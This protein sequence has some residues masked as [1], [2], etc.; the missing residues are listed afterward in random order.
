M[1]SELPDPQLK[2]ESRRRLMPEGSSFSPDLQDGHGLLHEDL[3][4][5]LDH[6]DTV[7]DEPVS[8]LL[9]PPGYGKSHEAKLAWTHLSS[10]PSV[11]GEYIH[12]TSFEKGGAKEAVTPGW[13]PRWSQDASA[14]A[15]WIVDAVDED[16]KGSQTFA[17]LK[18]IGTLKPAARSRLS[19]V[20]FCRENEFLRSIRNELTEI[21]PP[22][23]KRIV[24][25][26]API[27][28]DIARVIA[29][30]EG[31]LHRVCEIIRL[32]R[33]QQVARFPAVIRYLAKLP[34]QAR[35]TPSTV[36]RNVLTMMLIDDRRAEAEALNRPDEK[37]CFFAAKRLAACM[38][39]SGTA[40]IA[41]TSAAGLPNILSDLFQQHISEFARYRRAASFVLKTS[42]CKPTVDGYR[43]AQRHIQEWFAAFAFEE[44][45]L[46]RLRSLFVDQQGLMIPEHQGILALLA[47][48]SEHAEVR[49]WIPSLNDGVPLFSDAAPMTLTHAVETLDGLVTIANRA[50]FGLGTHRGRA[51]TGLAVHGL[52][53]IV[54]ARLKEK[55]NSP[56]AKDLL[57]DIAGVLRLVEA[58]P[59]AQDLIR[60]E[61]EDD[62]VRS[63]AV[64]LLE[65][66]ASPEQIQAVSMVAK[67]IPSARRAHAVFHA[68]LLSLLQERGIWTI[69]QVTRACRDVDGSADHLV[70]RLKD[71]MS[72]SDAREILRDFDWTAEIAAENA[73]NPPTKRRTHDPSGKLALGLEAI[74]LF[75]KAPALNRTDYD[76]LMPVVMALSDAYAR[77]LFREF[78]DALLHCFKQDKDARRALFR[79][80]L[81]SRLASA[82]VQGGFI[83]HVLEP[84]DASWL[85]DQCRAMKSVPDGV[86]DTLL[87]LSYRAKDTAEGADAHTFLTERIP[88]RVKEFYAQAEKNHA[89]YK[90]FLTEEATRKLT[91]KSDELQIAELITTILE[92]HKSQPY[93]RTLRIAWV[94][95]APDGH[96][97]TNVLGTWGDVPVE[98]KERVRAAVVEDLRVSKAPALSE[99]GAPTRHT[100]YLSYAFAWATSNTPEVLS[101]D[102]IRT[103]LPTLLHWSDQRNTAAL[104]ACH[105]ASETATEDV[106]LERIAQEARGLVVH[107]HL[108]ERLPATY[109]SPR[110]TATVIDLLDDGA[111]GPGPRSSLIRTIA[112]RAPTQALAIARCALASA[113]PE[114]KTAAID[115]LLMLEPSR[116]IEELLAF[117]D[118]ARVETLK[119]LE[120]LNRDRLD[121]ERIA[122]WSA[123]DL[124]ALHVLLDELPP[125]DEDDDFSWTTGITRRIQW[126]ILHVLWDRQGVDDLAAI[127]RIAAK[128]KSVLD[129]FE[130]QKSRQAAGTLLESI[131]PSDSDAKTYYPAAAFLDV[132]RVLDQA[133]FRLIRSPADL[134]LVVVEEIKTIAKTALDHLSMLYQPIKE[135][136]TKRR[137]LREEALQ[138]YLACRLQDRLP[139]RVLKDAKVH[140]EGLA[141]RNHR[142]DL[143]IDA[144]TIE[145]HLVSIILELKWS[146]NESLLESLRTQLGDDYLETQNLTHGVYVVG[147]LR[148]KGQIKSASAL[149]EILEEQATEYRS[150]PHG[151]VIAPLVLDL[152]WPYVPPTKKI[153]PKK[154][155]KAQ[156]PKR[157]VSAK[158]PA[159]PKTQPR[160]GKPPAAKRR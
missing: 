8:I 115:A 52:G 138:T 45:P 96:R 64:H 147:W 86:W 142:T 159:K 60:D 102:L 80:E 127:Q 73:R 131:V 149:E 15:C 27:T 134:A 155:A 78:P 38:A 128:K 71:I 18:Q 132:V 29:G 56:A 111:V 40:E 35:I 137:Q 41:E 133:T 69:P 25:L 108:A 150:R 93:E 16:P 63:A 103:W 156:K 39:L 61:T 126:S 157:A 114:C 112:R 118:D 31:A 13:W 124:E 97:P 81:D 49:S 37:D 11:F 123:P 85:A 53:E 74:Q 135:G 22:G 122:S 113:F 79:A 151:R 87:N 9:A 136:D 47:Q 160:G 36:W 130:N 104:K 17:I 48:V 34:A 50:P 75:V 148:P 107:T 57:L 89:K 62:V 10:H 105:A 3:A 158:P 82:S 67:I 19:L 152:S 12:E 23:P 20:M 44:V 21:Y 117:P 83:R 94:C 33:L 65:E 28:A 6:I 92:N 30:G 55:S 143:R 43:F 140:R 101:P 145:Q 76:L 54:A 66:L 68:G 100:L 7:F 14:R 154:A 77:D 1:V 125:E 42:V 129:W 5:S 32:N 106:I 121:R 144:V 51:L 46:A 59:V 141:A 119:S 95:F 84:V 110:V 70:Y 2:T 99:D 4:Y 109:W 116:A 90:E 120:T 72:L 24:R 88:D 58:V 98:L 139:G 153:T 91:K 26:L 146:A